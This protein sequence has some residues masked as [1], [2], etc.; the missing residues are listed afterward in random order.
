MEEMEWNILTTII[1]TLIANACHLISRSKNMDNRELAG[2]V[3]KEELEYIKSD[4]IRRLVLDC[5]D[6]LTP[7][8]FWEVAGSSSGLHH[9]KIANR[10][11]GL[12]MHVK[13]CVWWGRKLAESFYR[14]DMDIIIAA[15]LLHDLQ[16]FG[17][18]MSLYDGKPTL[19]SYTSTHGMLMAVQMMQLLKKQEKIVHG[20]FET[21][22]ACVGL[23]MGRWTD[24][25]LGSKWLKEY[26][27]NNNV[28]IVQMADYCA[29]RKVGAKMEELDKWEFP[30]REG[31]VD[32][33]KD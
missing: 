29:S 7:D 4:R 24:E 5:F 10:K 28:K 18:E 31:I 6:E 20:T 2:L 22:T 17:L 25:I 27:D 26:R 15:L 23:H 8:Y 9:P 13:L 16:K 21:I 32:D 33:K 1:Y 12:I 14:Y 11:H 3:F 30:G 19:A